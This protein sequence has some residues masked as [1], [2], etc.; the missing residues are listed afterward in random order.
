MTNKESNLQSTESH[1]H[2]PDELRR[3][4]D[5]WRAERQPLGGMGREQG[6]AEEEVRAELP[7]PDEL[8]AV[9]GRAGACSGWE[10]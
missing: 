2:S 10:G 8:A 4:G 9:V 5:G 1:Q 6:S 7:A 3:G